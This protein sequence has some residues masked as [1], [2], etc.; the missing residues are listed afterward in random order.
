MAEKNLASARLV[1]KAFETGDASLID[2]A[3]AT[4][5]VDHTD[6]GDL[7]RDSLKKMVTG[8][9][10]HFPDMKMEVLKE[11]ADD[12]Y[13]FTHVRYTGTSSGAM[14][15]PKGPYDM[16]VIHVVRFKDGKGVE[17]WEFMQPREMMA[18]SPKPED[19]GKK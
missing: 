6:R 14:D 3:I 1:N 17:H 2:S 19:K 9:K 18:L 16:Q 4:D 7:N 15:M 13:V 5:F 11:L 10:Q 8:I 12:E